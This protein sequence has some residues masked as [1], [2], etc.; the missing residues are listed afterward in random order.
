MAQLALRDDRA[1]EDADCRQHRR[2]GAA[3]AMIVKS[4]LQNS[5][6][7]SSIGYRKSHPPQGFL[8][9]TNTIPAN[10]YNCQNFT[11]I[12]EQSFR[13][14]NSPELLEHDQIGKC[15]KMEDPNKKRLR[16]T[17]PANSVYT[18][19]ALSPRFVLTKSTNHRVLHRLER[20]AARLEERFLKHG[21]LHLATAQMAQLGRCSKRDLYLLAPSRERV[22]E[23]IVRR[24][25][26]NLESGMTAVAADA[27]DSL[28][29]LI[30]YLDAGIH[31]IRM[32]RYPF[33]KDVNAFP[34]ARKVLRGIQRRWAVTVEDLL[35]VGVKEHI[36]TSIHP[37]LVAQILIV[38]AMKLSDPAFLRAGGLTMPQAFDEFFR[39]FS[40]GLLPRPGNAG[41]APFRRSRAGNGTSPTGA[42]SS[43]DI[44]HLNHIHQVNRKKR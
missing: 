1:V 41:A 2:G 38:V 26:A 33:I 30:R 15:T 39:L 35:V 18:P 12:V 31:G 7:R 11:M 36:F 34:P 44:L 27:P 21:F 16:S 24:Y 13:R 20:I 6:V 3:P 23:L 29:A 8:L 10:G 25:F 19:I 28:S 17:R 37:Y 9:Q 42:Q 22:F 40:Y 14:L 32:I 4:R 43:P 5:E